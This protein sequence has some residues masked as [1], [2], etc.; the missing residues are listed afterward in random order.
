[1]TDDRER[2]RGHLGWQGISSP[3]HAT[4]AAA[5]D[6][7]PF[8]GLL[9]EA[10]YPYGTFR[11]EDGNLFALARRLPL[12]E[13]KSRRYLIMQTTLDFD[14]FAIH[15]EGKKSGSTDGMIREIDG[16]VVTWRK[17]PDA[18]GKDFRLIYEPGKLTWIEED[19]VHL[20]GKLRGPGLQWYL[21]GPDESMFFA[22]QMFEFE[23]EILGRKVQGV[24]ALDE[25]YLPEGGEIYQKKDVLVGEQ[26][27]Y[28][29]YTF[30]TRYSDGSFEGG[31]VVMGKDQAGFTILLNQD[32]K[33][34]V[35]DNDVQ[36]EI[37]FSEDGGWPARID[38]DINGE[39]WEF[40]PDPR[41]RMDFGPIPNPNTEGRWQRVGETRTPVNWF[42]W[43]EIAP[44]HGRHRGAIPK[45]GVARG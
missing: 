24:G 41:G 38:L 33:I 23:G 45:Q 2:R 13:D 5:A 9:P 16:D 35:Q 37:T 12:K 3:F 28:L 30:G 7:R 34:I 29:W 44:G 21:P 25:I 19:I 10:R 14:Q 1:M 18:K 15:P 42:A 40:L 22:S 39:H 17:A 27:E 43:G 32:E 8:F 36:G 31:H 26:V 6:D 20:V 11:D 4:P